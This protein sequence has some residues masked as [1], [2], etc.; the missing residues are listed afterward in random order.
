M[1]NH[2][3]TT[4]EA[5]RHRGPQR[6]FRQPDGESAFGEITDEDYRP[7]TGTQ[8]AR[9][10]R[11][12]GALASQPGNIDVTVDPGDDRT[13]WDAADQVGRDAKGRVGDKVQER[14]QRGLRGCQPHEY[15]PGLQRPCRRGIHRRH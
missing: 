4:G 6:L 11:C 7:R 12:T 8:G 1:P 5:E 10:V 14:L 13:R 15:S 3:E 2:R 9:G